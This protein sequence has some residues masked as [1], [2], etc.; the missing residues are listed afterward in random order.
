M[1]VL[2]SFVYRKARGP[3]ASQP[4]VAANRKTMIRKVL[5]CENIDSVNIGLKKTLLDDFSFQVEQ[6]QY[7]DKAL[8]MFKNA[9]ID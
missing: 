7:C 6:A 4:R 3:K 8:L 5:I 9:L 1:K 2:N